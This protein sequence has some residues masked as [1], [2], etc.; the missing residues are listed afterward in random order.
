LVLIELKNDKEELFCLGFELKTISNSIF[1]KKSE[2][3]VKG[4]VYPGTETH[5]V[6]RYN[7]ISPFIENKNVLDIACGSGYGSL[8]LAEKGNPKSVVSVDIDEEAIRYGNY[9]YYNQKI[10]RY[11]DDATKY[12]STLMF[13][14]IVCFETIEHVLDYQELVEN[15]YN[16]L[17]PD[18]VIYISTPI[19][20]FT[21]SKVENPYHVIEW[22]FFD[23]HKL[24]IDKFEISEILLQ[25][26][27]I[28]NKNL[29]RIPKFII[30]LF[31][32]ISKSFMNKNILN[33][34][35]MGLSMEIYNGQYDMKYAKK[36]FQILKLK[37]K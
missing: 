37:K 6:D 14:V 3:W 12:K 31:N 7:Y 8:I 32:K 18:G 19:N 22:S 5:H 15:H 17:H 26:V 33:K 20:I 2:R 29:L 34:E 1:Y 24:F 36:G 16:L 11:V 28:I 9:R 13:D 27:V 23:F 35:K 25:N 30:K 4:F 10:N 21:T